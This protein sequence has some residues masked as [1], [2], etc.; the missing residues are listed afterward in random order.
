ML[1]EHPSML[2]EHPSMLI[3]HPKRQMILPSQPMQI[4]QI[5]SKSELGNTQ[6]TRRIRET[7][8]LR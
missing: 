6:E 8:A 4:T 7:F 2:I 3:E 5:T 1:I